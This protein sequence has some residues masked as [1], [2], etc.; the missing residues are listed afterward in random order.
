MKNDSAGWIGADTVPAIAAPTRFESLDSLRGLCACLVAAG[1]LVTTSPLTI[2]VFFRHS[3][4]FV[5][6]FFVLSGFVMCWNYKSRLATWDEVKS[7]FILRIGRLYPLHVITLLALVAFELLASVRYP[8]LLNH[9]PFAA[10]TSS[11]S[12]LSN[13]LMVQALNL[14]AVDTWNSP[15][16][17]ISTELWTY[18]VFAG[19]VFTTGLRKAYLLMLPVLVIVMLQAPHE[20]NS[21]YDFGFPR[22]LLGFSL[23]VFCCEMFKL[24][25]SPVIRWQGTALEL[26]A[27]ASVGLV[28]GWGLQPLVA[29]FVMAFAVLVFAHDSGHLSALLRARPFAALGKTSYSIY[30]LHW[31]VATAF[32]IAVNFARDHLGVNLW[33]LQ[34]F[35]GRWVQAYGTSA[36]QGNL[37][38]AAFLSATIILS[39]VTYKFI[40]QPGRTWARQYGAGFVP[41]KPRQ[42]GA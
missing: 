25:R 7:F 32:W 28:I 26:I 10:Q 29:P 20:M 12:I 6:F 27:A 3:Y 16:W 38:I 5:D 40:E 2:S 18:L 14:H 34:Y 8:H 21:T 39:F 42:V 31:S 41:G 24:S 11:T 37:F 19:I 33:G 1:H 4:L 22:C 23:G 35:E 36:S 17:S 30:M 15:S 13:L 9:A